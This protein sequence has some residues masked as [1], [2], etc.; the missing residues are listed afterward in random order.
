MKVSTHLLS[1]Q[2]SARELSQG[3]FLQLEKDLVELQIL[4]LEVWA[5]AWIV[6]VCER[7]GSSRAWITALLSGAGAAPLS[8]ETTKPQVQSPPREGA[9]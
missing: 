2:D 1:G 5:R 4:T 3:R 6:Y 8:A 7:E 9:Q